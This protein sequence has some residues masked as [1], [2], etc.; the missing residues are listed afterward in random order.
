MHSNGYGV[1][2]MTDRDIRPVM[3]KWSAVGIVMNVLEAEDGVS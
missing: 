1:A 3:Q 2:A